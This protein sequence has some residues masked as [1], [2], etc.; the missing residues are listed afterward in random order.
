MSS[1]YIFNDTIII[2]IDD[3]E[4]LVSSILMQK[5]NFHSTAT[6]SIGRNKNKNC[7]AIF[8]SDSLF[9]CF[10]VFFKLSNNRV[11]ENSGD[12]ITI[13]TLSTLDED[14]GQSFI[15]TL[16][17]NANGRFKIQHD[18][19]KVNFLSDFLDTF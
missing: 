1:A 16:P 11:A 19:L 3:S 14:G 6:R 2:Y 18:Q 12:N 17:E 10:F 8:I 13:A 9:T 4:L 15:Y 5:V 7:F